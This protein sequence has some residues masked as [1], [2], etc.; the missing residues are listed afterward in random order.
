MRSNAA[1]ILVIPSFYPTQEDPI[2]GIFFKEQ[3]CMTQAAGIRVGIIYPE[4]RPLKGMTLDLFY[5]NYFQSNHYNEEGVPTFRMHGWN[6]FPGY[7]KGT[8]KY[9]TNRALS[10]FKKYV[11]SQGMP[12]L[13]HAQSALWAGAAAK[14]IADRYDIPYVLTEHRDNFLHQTLLPG[15]Q[16][17]S[18]LEKLMHEVL[19]NA[20]QVIAVSHAL[21]KGLSRYMI[22]PRNQ[23]CVIPNFID[24]DEFAPL[25]KPA[26]KDLFTFTTI[27]HLMRSKNIDVLLHAFHLLLKKDPGNRLKIGGNGPERDFLEKKAK[28]LG[29]ASRVEFLGKLNRQ[30]VKETL[31][32]SHAFVLPSRYETFGV[33]LIEALSM[34]LPVIGTY[35]GGPEDIIAPEVGTLVPPDDAGALMQG[36]LS[37]KH[38]YSTYIPADSRQ[39][40]ITHFG[41]QNVVAKLIATYSQ[42]IN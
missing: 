23:V 31:S 8:M 30:Q 10:L 28:D 24:T 29:I 15:L 21:K 26:P 22:H 17:D 14:S 27:A 6:I 13:I 38:K 37:I 42:S 41:K 36:M 5:K 2:H 39:Y 11:K 12:D 4:V 1:H 19:D 25:S 32:T 35:S 3:A 18:W 7:L 20:N 40:A 9:W 16:K 34:G 33:V